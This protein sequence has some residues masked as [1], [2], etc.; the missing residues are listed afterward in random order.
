MEVLL[1]G[2]G[3]ADG[4]PN[5]FCRCASCS[6]QLADGVLRTPT[7]ALVD[8]VLL[9]DCG[10]ETPRS[11]LRAGRRL[12]RL[13]AVLLTHAHPDHSAP[14]ALL[15]RSWADRTEPLLLAGPAAVL[16]DWR[17]W[18]G[19]DARVRWQPVTPG[20]RFSIGR[21]AVEALAADHDEPAVLWLVTDGEGRRLLYATDTGPLPAGTVA[22]LTGRRLDLLLLEDTFGDSATH[23]TRH[24]DLRSF[25]AETARL[26]RAGALDDDSRVV[27]VHLSHHNPP[28]EEL[29]RRLAELGASAGRDGEVVLSGAGQRRTPAHRTLVLGGARSGKSTAAERLLAAEPDVTYVATGRPPDDADADWAQRVRHH[30][31]RRPATWRTLETTDLARALDEARGPV[32]VDCLGTWLT[33]V[34]TDAGAWDDVARWEERAQRQVDELLRAWRSVDVPVVAVS[35]EVGSGVVPAHRSGG[36]FRDWLGRLNQAVAAAS[37]RSLLLVAGRVVELP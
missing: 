6:R 10:P 17:P 20:D 14:M 18:V 37:E 19:P 27:A 11:A 33:A 2:T 30:R 31:E 35:N 12:D 26:R 8:D 21:Y 24:L 5:A 29:G 28:E 1:L 22:A 23:G 13:E 36:V 7:S 16:D 32:L 4:W 25:A 9:L 34:L 15:A 3:S